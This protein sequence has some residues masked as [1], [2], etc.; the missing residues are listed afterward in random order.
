MLENL[1]DKCIPKT[2]KWEGQSA[3]FLNNKMDFTL[4]H[5]NAV[6]VI[7]Q[8]IINHQQVFLW[9]KQYLNS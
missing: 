2:Y 4:D 7:L 9:A 8:S 6:E 3:T 5:Q 1:L